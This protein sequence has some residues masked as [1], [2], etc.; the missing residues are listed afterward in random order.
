MGQTKGKAKVEIPLVPLMDWNFQQQPTSVTLDEHSCVDAH[1]ITKSQQGFLVHLSEEDGQVLTLRDGRTY[2]VLKQLKLSELQV[3]LSHVKTPTCL[4]A[5]RDTIAIGG[6]GPSHLFIRWNIKK[7]IFKAS[8][9]RAHK[10]GLQQVLLFGEKLMATSSH[11]HSVKVWDIEKSTCVVTLTAMKTPSAI[12][13]SDSGQFCIGGK[14]G[15]LLIYDSRSLGFQ[16]KKMEVD[17]TGRLGVSFLCYEPQGQRMAV[18]CSLINSTPPSSSSSSNRI[19][20]AI[21]HMEKYV[22]LNEWLAHAGDIKRLH[23]E[24]GI[25]FSIGE[26]TDFI[27]LWNPDT[28]ELLIQLD[29]LGPRTIR[30]DPLRKGLLVSTNKTLLNLKMVLYYLLPSFL[31]HFRTRTCTLT[32]SH[33]LVSLFLFRHNFQQ[34]RRR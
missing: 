16:P 29:I 23:W 33:D 31:F 15:V 27:R 17:K 13:I 18:G 26:G 21:L 8:L 34:R 19:P 12:A 5:L 2:E 7:Q 22:L 1:F 14:D 10:D 28:G 3:E 20:I 30:M 11:D 6:S 32:H 25:L 9:L 4:F 24:G